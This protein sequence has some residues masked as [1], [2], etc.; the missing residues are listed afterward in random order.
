MT[1]VPSQP[2]VLIAAAL[3]AATMSA[4][5]AEAPTCGEMDRTLQFAPAGDYVRPQFNVRLFSAAEAGCIDLA[6]RLLAAGASLE[7]R[8]RLGHMALARAARSG[9]LALAK[10]FLAEGAAIDARNL[11]GSTALFLATENQRQAT[12]NSC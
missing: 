12:V 1:V 10:L 5:A 9:Q 8:D 6:R 11:E 3:V 2:R 4:E 7:A